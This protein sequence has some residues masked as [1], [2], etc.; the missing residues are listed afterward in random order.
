MKTVVC[1]IINNN[2]TDKLFPVTQFMIIIGII[3]NLAI[4][5]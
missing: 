3:L 5:T 2:K 1:N 4:S